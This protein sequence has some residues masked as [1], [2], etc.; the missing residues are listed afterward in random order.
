MIMG[1]VVDIKNK[2]AQ[3][4]NRDCHYEFRVITDILI[5]HDPEALDLMLNIINKY[6]LLARRCLSYENKLNNKEYRK[7]SQRWSRDQ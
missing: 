1:K 6:D 7:E 5:K 3:M 4:K 2:L